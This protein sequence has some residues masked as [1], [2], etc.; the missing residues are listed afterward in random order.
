MKVHHL[1]CGTMTSLGAPMVCHVL[2]IETDAGLVLVDSG[3]GLHDC[4]E[5]ARRLG[6]LRRIIRPVLRPEET[7]VRQVERLGFDRTD[8]RHIV[9]THFDFDHI[10]GLADFPDATVHV[11][12]AEAE[13]AMRPPT[14][15]ERFR[16]RPAQWEHGPRLVEY[17]PTGESWRGFEAVRELDGVASGIALVFMPGHTR[18]HAAVAVDTGDRWIL[19][20]GD[21][22]YLRGSV[23]GVTPVPRAVALS[24]RISAFDRRQ[25]LANQERLAELWSRGDPDLM[26]VSA[27]DG[28]LLARAQAG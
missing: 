20:C 13:G 22:F 14:L 26:I 3:Y 4:A 12:A 19:H 7:A 21:A 9:T 23:D 24:A 17:E 1:N 18:G 6:P 25:L 28:E 2:V 15:G 27:H 16:F 10:G 8:V 11:T 5:P